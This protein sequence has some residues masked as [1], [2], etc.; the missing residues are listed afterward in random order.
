MEISNPLVT[1]PAVSSSTTYYLLGGSRAVPLGFDAI[2][3]ICLRVYYRGMRLQAFRLLHGPPYVRQ[4]HPRHHRREHQLGR[5]R[6]REHSDRIGLAVGYTG[7]SDPTGQVPSRKLLVVGIDEDVPETSAG[8]CHTGHEALVESVHSRHCIDGHV[9]NRP[10]AV[11]RMRLADSHTDPA[12]HS[13]EQAARHTRP[14]VVG[15][16][17]AAAEGDTVADNS[18]HSRQRSLALEADSLAGNLAGC[19]DRKDQTWRIG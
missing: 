13:W 19:T 5:A 15:I 16:D 7:C 11:V 10:R 6:P 18:G 2:L 3:C 8:N 17:A 4:T 1:E 14:V 12:R 9:G